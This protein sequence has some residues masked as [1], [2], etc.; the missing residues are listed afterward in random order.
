[1]NTFKD[2]G[3][4]GGTVFKSPFCTLKRRLYSWNTEFKSST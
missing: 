3:N 1:M 4:I 2:E